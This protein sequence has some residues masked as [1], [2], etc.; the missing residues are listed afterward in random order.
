MK[1]LLVAVLA[2]VLFGS[3][4]TYATETTLKAIVKDKSGDVTFIDG[5]PTSTAAKSIDIS[6]VTFSKQK[7]KLRVV[8]TV[9]EG[10]TKSVLEQYAVAY[11]KDPKTGIKYLIQVDTKSGS[12]A[13]VAKQSWANPV[14]CDGARGSVV[15]GKPG[16]FIA[17]VP[18]SCLGKPARLKGLSALTVAEQYEVGTSSWKTL[19]KDR[20]SG[21]AVLRLR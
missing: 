11:A 8:T 18:L 5:L 9:R 6:K 10:S 2:L 21:K 3:G 7:R 12:Q 17:T 15:H 20:A 19:S 4:A 13:Y 16:R 14:D 1:R